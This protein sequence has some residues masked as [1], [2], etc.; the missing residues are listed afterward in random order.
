MPRARQRGD[1]PHM[2]RGNA[3][4][5]MTQAL[6]G[7]SLAMLWRLAPGLALA[8]TCVFLSIEARFRMAPTIVLGRVIESRPQ[9]EQVTGIA[10][11]RIA[12]DAVIRGGAGAELIVRHA[13]DGNV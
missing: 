3:V 2:L 6:V 11:T 13:V 4:M 5:R 12:V 1:R 10:V 7:A 9:S 8:C